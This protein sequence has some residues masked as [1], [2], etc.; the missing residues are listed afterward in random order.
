MFKRE[1][2][3]MKL[4]KKDLKKMAY[5]MVMGRQLENRITM[6][7]KESRLRGH[8][9]PGQ[10]QE[11]AMVGICYGLKDK[12]YISLSHRGKN[13]E[14]M[15]GMTLKDLM[16]GYYDKKEGVGG[17]GRVPAGS[18]MYGDISKG[19]IPMPGPIGGV[20]PIA[21]GVG[22]GLKMDKNKAVMMAI[23][24]DGACNRG[25]FHEAVNLAAALKLPVIFVLVN[26]GFAMSVS[27]EK[28]T[29]LK[30]LSDRAKG[31]GIPGITV[32]GNDV[33]GVYQEA[34]K[35]IDHARKGKGPSLIECVVHRWT[36]H[37]ISDADIYRSDKQRQAGE[38]KDPLVRFKKELIK[39]GVLDENTYEDIVKQVDQ[40][41][42]EAVQY[43]EKDCSAPEPSDILRGVYA[44]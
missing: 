9:H 2:V 44:S 29:G 16:A 39:E 31:Y 19:I 11:A 22:L 43:S 34:S 38:K 27:V 30:T 17:G 4:S 5:W 35:A 6:L 40:E 12:D 10:G 8:H 42:E 14:L 1:K 25:D 23:F 21:S 41:I 26:N 15:K 13:P 37:S 18:H 36:G 20:L 33:R 32:D 3:H 28:S 24:G 7:F